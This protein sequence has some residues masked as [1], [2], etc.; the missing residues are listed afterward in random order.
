MEELVHGGIGHNGEVPEEVI[1]GLEEK[2]DIGGFGKGEHFEEGMLGENT[3]V[4]RAGISRPNTASVE[5]CCGLFL[6]TTHT[7]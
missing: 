1:V 6:L 3:S 7:P 5:G 4:T 2:V